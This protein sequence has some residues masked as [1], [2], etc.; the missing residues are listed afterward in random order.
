MQQEASHLP[1]LEMPSS[2]SA[3]SEDPAELVV[4][5]DAWMSMVLEVLQLAGE[6]LKVVDEEDVLE[7]LEL[8]QVVE[9][10]VVVG[11][12]LYQSLEAHLLDRNPLE[13]VSL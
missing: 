10:E 3:Y 7:L 4:V 9:V 13:E 5:E 2:R 12:R 1:L 6:G 8:L 11:L